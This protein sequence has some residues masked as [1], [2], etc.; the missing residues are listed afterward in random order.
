MTVPCRHA[1]VSAGSLDQS[2]AIRARIASM[3]AA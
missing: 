1:P 2:G 3:V